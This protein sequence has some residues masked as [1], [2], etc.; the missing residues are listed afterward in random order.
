MSETHAEERNFS[1]ELLNT[2]DRDPGFGRRAWPRR[3]ND[4][5]RFLRGDLGGSD[6]VVAVDFDLQLRIDFPQPLDQVVRE[7]IVVI[8]QQDHSGGRADV[9]D[10]WLRQD[11]ILAGNAGSGQWGNG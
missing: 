11:V 6:L 8:D 7:G 4:V 9:G 2:F 10:W 5:R 3:D 1:L